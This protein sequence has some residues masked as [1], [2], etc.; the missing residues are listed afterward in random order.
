MGEEASQEPRQETF[1]P[2]EARGEAFG[3]VEVQP[4]PGEAVGLVEA[5]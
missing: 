4:Y 3:P 1:R 5:P 2:V